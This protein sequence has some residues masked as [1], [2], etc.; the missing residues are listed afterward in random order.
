MKHLIVLFLVING[1]YFGNSQTVLTLQPDPTSG[2]DAILHGLSSQR[3][4]NFGTNQQFVANAWTFSGE[5]AQI[6]SVIDFNLAAIPTSSSILSAYLQLYA[7]DSSSG[8]GQHSTESG[9]NTCF[10]QRITSN[11]NEQTITW[12][13]Q[14]TTTES[15]QV[16]IPYTY[17]A[18]QNFILDVTKLLIDTKNNPNQSFGF[19]LK[20]KNETSKRRMNFASSDHPNPQLRPKLIIVYSSVVNTNCLFVQPSPESGKDALLHGLSSEVNKNYGTNP[21]FVASAWTFGGEEAKIRS[22]LD[23]EVSK[24]PK[25]IEIENAFL[26]LYSWG[27]N[28]GMGVH[29]TEAGSNEC[30]IERIITDWSESS[31]SWNNQ[32]QTTPL[33]RIS[34]DESNDGNQSYILDITNLIKDYY[35]DQ[36]HSFGL[37]IKLK[38]EIAKRRMNF[39]SSD[40]ENAN[41]RPKLLVSYKSTVKTKDENIMNFEIYPNPASSDIYIIS[42]NSK[43]DCTVEIYNLN[44]TIVYKNSNYHIG[45]ILNL[46][47]LSKGLYILN[48]KNDSAI[49]NKKLIIQ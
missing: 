38:S 5:D 34:I 46:D 2:K 40:H 49:Y 14:P 42:G 44:G 18:T 24:L 4:L 19:M 23:F 11:W 3:D 30:W 45:E 27:S 20:L 39:A 9:E 35:N 36:S 8:M 22:I 29:S 32:P 31:V 28:S 7:W 21:Q 25:N 33:N 26:S 47:S 16:E 12:N 17:Y 6:R 15:N 1:I 10:L 48:L 41:L 13:N 43:E 37:M